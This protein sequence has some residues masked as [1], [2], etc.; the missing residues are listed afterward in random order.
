MFSD[1]GTLISICGAIGASSVGY[2]TPSLLYLQTFKPEIKDAF[3]QSRLQGLYWFT[4]PMACLLF[5][6]VCLFAGTVETIL[7]M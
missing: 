1:L 4:M 7:A 3:R 2:I 5:G 6:L